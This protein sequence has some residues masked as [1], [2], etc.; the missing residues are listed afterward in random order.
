MHIWI[1]KARKTAFC[2]SCGDTIHIGDPIVRGRVYSKSETGKTTA[3]TFTWHAK[4]REGYCCWLEEG[5][6]NLA[7]NPWTETRGRKRAP[8]SEDNRT[9]RVRIMKRRGSVK[10][11]LQ[12]AVKVPVDQRDYDLI[13]SLGAQLEACKEEIAPLGGVPQGW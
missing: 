2:S 12:R 6:L 1:T 11:R 13:I 8:M 7:K 5:L 9:Q 10:Q 3:S 4:N